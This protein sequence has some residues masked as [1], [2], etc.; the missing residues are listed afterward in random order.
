MSLIERF[1][2][3]WV[4]DQKTGCWVWVAYCNNRREHDPRARMFWK[5][6]NVSASRVSWYLFKGEDPGNSC[7][8]HTCDNGMCV[9]PDHLWLGTI[10]DNNRDKMEKGRFVP[11]NGIQNGNAKLTPEDVKNIRRLYASGMTHQKIADLYNID[12]S[13]SIH[14]VNKK[15]WKHI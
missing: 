4:L 6:Q 9:N 11:N 1:N 14:I 3:K 8:C 10:A 5:G 13:T 15:T 7:V 2:K 12:R